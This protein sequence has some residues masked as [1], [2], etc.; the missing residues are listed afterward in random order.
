MQTRLLRQWA[1]FM[2]AQGR[3]D[4][5]IQQYLCAYAALREIRPTPATAGLWGD[6]GTGVIR[7]V[8]R[9]MFGQPPGIKLLPL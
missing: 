4:R 9:R 7:E 5:T 8:D 6:L 2:K 1:A 3:S